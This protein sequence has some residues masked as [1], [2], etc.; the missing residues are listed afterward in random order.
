MASCVS[1]RRR[2]REP[3]LV[4]RCLEAFW[5]EDFSNEI[6]ESEKRMA[7]A[8]AVV[9]EDARGKATAVDCSPE[10]AEILKATANYI[11]AEAKQ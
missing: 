7:A 4:R 5:H 11:F 8:L 2:V 6:L 9:A 1:E 3:G 10:L